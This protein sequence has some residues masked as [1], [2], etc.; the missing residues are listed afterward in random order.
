[1]MT[2]ITMSAEMHETVQ[3]EPASVAVRPLPLDWNPT[4]LTLGCSRW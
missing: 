4:A 3:L 1:M 2:A